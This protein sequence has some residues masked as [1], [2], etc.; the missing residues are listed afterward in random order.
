ME[1][2][3]ILTYPSTGLSGI[4]LSIRT[5]Y[6][7]RPRIWKIIQHYNPNLSFIENIVDPDQ[8]AS[9]EAIWSG[10]TMISTLIENTYL[11]LKYIAC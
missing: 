11:Q 7:W 9:D 6:S 10:S 5:K 4:L 1:S 2:A 3:T 8:L